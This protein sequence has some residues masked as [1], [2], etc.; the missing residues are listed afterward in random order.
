MEKFI[1]K[2]S[3]EDKERAKQKMMGRSQEV[4][5]CTVDVT[6]GYAG[7]KQLVGILKYK[8]FTGMWQALVSPSHVKE[9]IVCHDEERI[10]I[11]WVEKLF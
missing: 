8:I 6:I 2:L 9:G 11:M 7:N 1:S 3:V 5:K 10:C 4:R